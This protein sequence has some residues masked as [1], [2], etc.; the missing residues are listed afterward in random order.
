M[1]T[2]M[3]DINK[4]FSILKKK[5]EKGKGKNVIISVVQTLP[6]VSYILATRRNYH[7][8]E[9]TYFYFSEKLLPLFFFLI[10]PNSSFG[11]VRFNFC[12]QV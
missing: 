3:A 5:K 10:A 11:I 6:I 7:W 12:F 8:F 1:I 9:N 2:V 4:P